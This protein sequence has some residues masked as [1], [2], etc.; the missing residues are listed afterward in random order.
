LT[1]LIEMADL[2]VIRKVDTVYIRSMLRSMRIKL[3]FKTI[4]TVA[5]DEALLDSR[6]TENFLDLQAWKELR[7]G[8]FQLEKPVPVRNVD[9]TSNS[10]GHIKHFC[11]LKVRIKKC[12]KRMKFFLTNLGNNRF[13]LGY[14]FL[15]EFNP[16][17]DWEKAQFLD[18]ELEIETMG[19]QQ[20]QERM[21]RL[22]NIAIQKCGKPIEG[23]TLYLRKTM[24]SQKIAQKGRKIKG[25]SKIELP[26]EYQKHWKVFSKSQAQQFP[27]EREEN[28]AIKLLPNALTSIN[29]KVYPLNRK[30]T[31]T[32]RKFLAE[33]EKKGYIKQGSSPYTAPVFFVGKIDSEE[34]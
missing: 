23:H 7:I 24:A 32:L 28:M 11:W 12:E 20:A 31:D 33:E 30:E 4:S 10:A 21:Q 1:L 6:A 25:M 5:K 19:F 34:L 9:G 18:G 26:E 2:Q 16:R 13:I 8:R 22:Q 27:P 3:T 14:P 29:C 15:K 17:I